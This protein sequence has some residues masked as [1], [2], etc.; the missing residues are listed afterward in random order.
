MPAVAM[1]DFV[2]SGHSRSFLFADADHHVGIPSGLVAH[3][4]VLRSQSPVALFLAGKTSAQEL[5]RSGPNG[6]TMPIH[7]AAAVAHKLLGCG[8]YPS[9]NTLLG[10]GYQNAEAITMNPEMRIRTK[11]RNTGMSAAEDPDALEEMWSS[12]FDRQ[13]RRGLD[14]AAANECRR[15]SRK[16]KAAPVELGDKGSAFK[17]WELQRGVL[18]ALDG[19][20]V[21][22][23]VPKEAFCYR[24][25]LQGD[26]EQGL[27]RL[28]VN[29][30]C[31]P[32]DAPELPQGPAPASV[33]HEPG[34]LLRMELPK[35]RSFGYQNRRLGCIK[36]HKIALL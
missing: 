7:T 35:T 20:M 16:A 13:W 4:Q 12:R 27:L 30:S 23:R 32:A 14:V 5:L 8:G 31:L 18:R 33:V 15:R 10:V 29:E 21:F 11:L 3:G 22:G 19:F 2:V 28:Y 9:D 26:S 36:T 1:D 25:L 24:A 34:L 6:G 17:P